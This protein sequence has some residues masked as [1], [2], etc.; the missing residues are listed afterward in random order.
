MLGVGLL[1]VMI[2]ADIAL[3]LHSKAMRTRGMAVRTVME[4]QATYPGKLMVRLTTTEP[5][6]YVLLADTLDEMRGLGLRSCRH[7]R[8]GGVLVVM[9]GRAEDYAPDVWG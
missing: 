4:D 5:I 9:M 7:H 8:P 1:G 2:T 3:Q 6:P